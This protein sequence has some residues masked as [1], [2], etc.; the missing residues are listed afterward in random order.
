M[1]FLLS[2]VR[3]IAFYSTIKAIKELYPDTVYLTC[4]LHA[5]LK[6]QTNIKRSDQ[7]SAYFILNKAW[8]CYKAKDKTSFA[9]RIRRLEEITKQ[10]IADGNLKTSILNLCNKKDNFIKAYD[11][12]NCHRTSNMLDRLMKFQNRKLDNAQHFHG[13]LQSANNAVRAHALLVNFCPYNS[14]TIRLNGGITCPFEKLNGF[15]Y[16]DNWLENLLVASSMNG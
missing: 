10:R 12:H 5:C 7:E 11:F 6:I 14:N 2:K 9:Q 1:L 8:E 4:F 16:R 3:R 15:R 13:K